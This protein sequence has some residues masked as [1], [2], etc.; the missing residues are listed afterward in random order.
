MIHKS[1]PIF[2]Y[3][4]D[5]VCENHQQC[6]ESRNDQVHEWLRALAGSD[7][8]NHKKEGNI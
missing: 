8:G 6:N 2:P 5:I 4:A 1:G 7:D 3:I